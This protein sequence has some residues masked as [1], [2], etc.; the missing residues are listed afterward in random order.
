MSDLDLAAL[1]DFDPGAL[2]DGLLKDID[3]VHERLA[4]AREKHPIMAGNPF[5]AETHNLVN[6]SEVSPA[7]ISFRLASAAP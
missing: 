1:D 7:W 5:T 3:N 2:Q 4:E 6:P